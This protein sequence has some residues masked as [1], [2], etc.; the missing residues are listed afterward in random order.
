[1]TIHLG[2][3]SGFEAKCAKKQKRPKGK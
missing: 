1:L 2:E 3:G